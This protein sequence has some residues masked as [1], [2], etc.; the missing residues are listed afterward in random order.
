ML[1]CVLIPHLRTANESSDLTGLDIEDEEV[2]EE[3]G[4]TGEKEEEEEGEG[5]EEGSEEDEPLSTMTW[6]TV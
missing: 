6:S 3:E 1:A 2:L 4:V 5:N